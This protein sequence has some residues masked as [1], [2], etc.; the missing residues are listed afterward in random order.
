M[1]AKELTLRLRADVA[2]N[3]PAADQHELF[4]AAETKIAIP[5]SVPPTTPVKGIV[6]VPT[7]NT[8]MKPGR[9]GQGEI[10]QAVAVLPRRSCL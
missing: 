2:G 1:H 9:R 6:H 7:H 4:A 3:D 8:P 5:W 10:Q